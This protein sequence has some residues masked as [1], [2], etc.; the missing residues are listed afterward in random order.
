MLGGFKRV[1]M[2]NPVSHL[3]SVYMWNLH[4]NSEIQL[5]G[6]GVH[7]IKTQ[8]ARRMLDAIGSH[9]GPELVFDLLRMQLVTQ[10]SQQ[11]LLTGHK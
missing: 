11:H 4:L 5:Q 3:D 6:L 9:N 10:L 7:P 2:I 1:N 8:W